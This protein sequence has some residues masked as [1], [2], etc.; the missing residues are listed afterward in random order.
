MRVR[1]RRIVMGGMAFRVMETMAPVRSARV[2][3]VLIHGIGMSHR[4]LASLH[5]ELALATRVVSVDLPGFAGLPK[6]RADVDIPQ[7][8]AALAD[9]LATLGDG[10]LVLV[11]HSMGAQWA[12]E[13][14]IQQPVL[15]AGLVLI[16]PVTD[17]K[18]QTL[19]GQARALALDTV[20]ETP[21][22]NAVV[23]TDYVRC[24][25]R[26]YLTQVRH[27]LAFPMW[28]RLGAVAMPVLIIRGDKDPVSGGEWC[29]SLRRRAQFGRLVELPGQ[30]HVVQQSAPVAVASEI[31][32]WAGF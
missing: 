7:M 24:G 27:M 18:R 31:S 25:V 29:E 32:R 9:A 12:V 13:V 22:I 3:V 6:P 8:A 17:D 1:R 11:G 26:W 14:A 19:G 2:T 23:F 20:G 10:R 15:V 5:R 30:H 16:G 21:A 28:R 4:Y